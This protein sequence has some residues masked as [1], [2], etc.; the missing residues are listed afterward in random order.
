MVVTKDEVMELRASDHVVLVRQAVRKWA[1]EL[2]FSLVAT[3]GT[4]AAIAAA[5]AAT[6]ADQ[7]ASG[8][9]AGGEGDGGEGGELLQQC[10]GH[11]TS[12]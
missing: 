8:Q 1:I 11:R 9:P 4:A 3:R 7:P 2:G 10:V 6:A 5:G 12:R